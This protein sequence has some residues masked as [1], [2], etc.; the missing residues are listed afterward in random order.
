MTRRK[1]LALSLA[2]VLALVATSG[3]GLF[4]LASPASAAVP[5]WQCYVEYDAC[6]N[7]VPPPLFCERYLNFCLATCY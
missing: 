3:V 2:F 6:I 5:C 7:E 4:A 1:N